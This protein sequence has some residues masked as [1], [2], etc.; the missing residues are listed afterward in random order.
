ML[1]R[2]LIVAGLV[3]AIP[4]LAQ[5]GKEQQVTKEM[6]QPDHQ[7]PAAEP[8]QTV[9]GETPPETSTVTDSAQPIDKRPTV[10]PAPEASG[11]S[12]PPTQ[13]SLPEKK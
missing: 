6:V 7:K 13:Q 8:Q 12:K 1:V 9:P 4:A 2:P 3:F 5:T 11:S 10:G